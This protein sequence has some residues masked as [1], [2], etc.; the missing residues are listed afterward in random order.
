MVLR[1]HRGWQALL[2]AAASRCQSFTE[3]GDPGAGRWAAQGTEGW[4][5]SSPV[6]LE[7][8]L[9]RHL[10]VTGGLVGSLEPALSL[11]RSGRATKGA[12]AEMYAWR[13]VL[14]R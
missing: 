9:T 12:A 14:R 5:V 3:V 11:N 7:P 4:S 1:Q 6:G 8:Q 10:V 13:S 2:P